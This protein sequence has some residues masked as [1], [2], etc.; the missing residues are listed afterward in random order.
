LA[1]SKKSKGE[2]ILPSTTMANHFSA[3]GSLYN[4]VTNCVDKEIQ[5][6]EREKTRKTEQTSANITL[7]INAR[8]RRKEFP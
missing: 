5:F 1:V 3:F 6:R 8:E 4:T 2:T 7:C